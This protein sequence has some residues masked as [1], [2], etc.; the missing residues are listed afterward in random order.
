MSKIT[1]NNVSRSGTTSTYIPNFVEMAFCGWTDVRTLTPA[2]RR[3][4]PT[5]T[6]L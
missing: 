3:N 1:N 2:T 4:R 5:K 6:E